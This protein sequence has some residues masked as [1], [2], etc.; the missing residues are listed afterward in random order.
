MADE[1]D[2][3][4]VEFDDDGNPITPKSDKDEGGDV[5]PDK[6]DDKKIEEEEGDADNKGD[7]TFDDSVEPVIP[8]RTNLQHIVARKDKKIKKLEKK[9]EEGDEE[10][11]ETELS[12][13]AES[14]IDERIV[15]TLEPILGKLASDSDERE[16]QNL[17]AGDSE[18]KKYERHIRAY[19]SHEAYKNVA[20]SVIYHHLAFTNALAI[21]AKKKEVADL[22]ANQQKGGGRDLK[23]KG[24]GVGNLPSP[25]EIAEMSDAEIQKM[26]DDVMEGKYKDN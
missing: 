16:L 17:I 14:I 9:I 18:A 19:M 25:E 21:G 24:T 20:P 11:D 22:E 7:N 15:K 2:T 10:D 13:K 3:V 8:T 26:Q 1:K 23:P 4:D 6:K 5:D 12:N